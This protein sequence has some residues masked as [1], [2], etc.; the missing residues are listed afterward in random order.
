MPR[1]SRV[2]TAFMY[3]YFRNELDLIITSEW[4][5]LD[6]MYNIKLFLKIRIYSLVEL[7]SLDYIDWSLNFIESNNLLC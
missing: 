4:N 6:S 2:K 1:D 7:E 5:I 3:F